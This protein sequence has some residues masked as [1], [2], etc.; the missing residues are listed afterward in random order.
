VQDAFGTL[1][2]VVA[3]VGAVVAVITLLGTARGYREIGGGGLTHDSDARPQAALD[4]ERDEE[5][6]QMLDARNARRERRGEAPVDLEAELAA[7]DR[8]VADAGLRDE[9]RDLVVARNHRR[10][11]AGQEPLDVEAEVERRIRDL[12]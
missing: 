10:V 2:F 11:R 1:V 7:L 4:A 3:A 5:I 12:N 9:V 8:P 6:R